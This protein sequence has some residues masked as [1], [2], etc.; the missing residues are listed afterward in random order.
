MNIEQQADQSV[1]RVRLRVC[2]VAPFFA[3]LLLFAPLRWQR[4]VAWG[5]TD[6]EQILLNPEAVVASAESEIAARL[7]HLVLHAA[8]LHPQRG[9]TRD[10]RRWTVACD[11]VVNGMLA[12][13]PGVQLWPSAVREPLLEHLSAEEIY[14][15]VTM[16]P[17]HDDARDMLPIQPGSAHAAGQY[18]AHARQQAEQVAGGTHGDQHHGRWG[19]L[20]SRDIDGLH[21]HR[22]DWRTH[23]WRF[24]V[25]TP[26]DY[27][28]YDRRMLWQ[29]LYLEALHHESVDVQICIDTSG[30]ISRALLTTFL[31]EVHGIIGCYPQ[32]RGAIWFADADLA[33]PFPLTAGMELPAPNGGGGTDFQPFFAALH[34]HMSPFGEQIAIYLTDGYGCFPP[35]A[36]AI[37][38]LWVVAPGGLALDAFPF[39]DTLRVISGA[40]DVHDQPVSTQS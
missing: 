5:G 34:A 3:T 27:G 21:A 33:G 38:T 26:T 15:L 36:P 31:S 17:D 14:E 37:P 16:T 24:M 10:E 12:R 18:W 40:P 20:G 22:L 19:A 11:V 9:G 7:L 2:G 1:R 39:G 4:D 23:L 13:T 8:L 25:Q 28:A 29:G 6:G 30:S 32:I 35:V